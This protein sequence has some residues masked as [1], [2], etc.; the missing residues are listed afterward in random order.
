[1][2]S[3]TV[4]R[5]LVSSAVIL[6][7]C[8]STAPVFGQVRIVAEA[9]SGGRFGVGKLEI[10]L[11]KAM[12]PEALGLEA[13]CLT[14]RDGRV[15]YPTIHAPAIGAVVKEILS[16][17][18]PLLRG[19]P[20]ARQVG[21]LLGSILDRPPKATIYFLFRGD[22]PL[23][24]TLQG[25]TA[26]RMTVLARHDPVASRNLLRAW[27]SQYTA[28]PGLLEK[29]PD[30]PPLVD[31]YLKTTLARRLSLTLPESEQ[32]PSWQVELEEALGLMLGTESIRI[33]MQQDRIL[34]LNNLDQVAD[35]PL[36]APLPSPEATTPK[37]PDDVEVEPIAMR[38]PEE[39]FYVRFGSFANFL[40]MQ[41]T[42]AKW[43]GDLQNLLATRGLSYEMSQRM[44][45]QLVL[46]Q[47]ALS[48]MLG[49]TLIADVAII[50]NDM[51]FREGAAYGIL[52]YARNSALLGA[53]FAAQRLQRVNAG[54]VTE[55]K[56]KLGDSTVSLLASPDGSVRSYYA[57]DGDFHLVTTSRTLAARFLE[58]KSAAGSLGSSDNFRHARALMPLKRED[59][60]FVYF[61]DAF[62]RTLTGPHYR[63]EMARRL[64]AA[65]DVDLVQLAVL[66]SASEGKPGDTIAQLIAGELLPPEFGPR[67]DGSRTVLE[68]GQVYDQLRG[69]RGA[70]LPVPDVPT[71]QITRAELA[72]YRRFT[73]FYREKWGPLDPIMAAVKREALPEN[74]EKVTLD[75]RMSPLASKQYELLAGVVGSAEP[76]Q[77]APIPGDI[78][79]GEL[80]LKDQRLFGG[81]ADFGPPLQLVDGQ[82][83]PTGRLRDVL[84]GYVGVAG[85]LGL[86]SL[87]DVQIPA[88]P[89]GHGYSSNRLGLWRRQ[90]DQFTV[91]SLHPEVLAA[92]TPR[93]QFQQAVRPAQLRMRIG[94]VSHARMT[95]FLNNWGYA[96]TRETSLSNLR[97]INALDQQLHVP[98]EDCRAAAELLLDAKLVCPLGGQYVFQKRPDGSGY[99][100]STALAE[101]GGSLLSMRA[102]EGYQAPPL[103]W[104][105]G[106]TLDGAM[107]NEALTAHVEIIMQSPANE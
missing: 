67:P 103:N 44:E 72:A 3:N 8:A 54:G 9:F 35:Q 79:A 51:F 76:S 64:Q 34:G 30:Y 52:F 5:G 39:C 28:T 40:W 56:I 7:A 22:A 55:T 36:P 16:E 89:D 60:V 25:R 86:L 97:L 14:E 10:D 26:Y 13:L 48:R 21:G 74:R 69:H 99:W 104:F 102:P 17:D 18:S 23:E 107:T 4:R 33:A 37:P 93:L 61:S 82:M 84:V 80:V 65:A 12:L 58:T 27:W 2:R 106:L 71:D 42:L 50:G 66:A 98:P 63:V 85:P 45:T 87:L 83:L 73:D 43:Q 90:F 29:K 59:T 95:P 46:K 20:L 41:D 1:M 32:A 94:D 101:A 6:L 31:S 11:H 78:A 91:F 92:V 75:L 77:L 19:R 24:L 105:R 47:N 81:L 38:V 96:R 53:D 88:A 70:L 68:D 57:T 100:T 62:F 15:L 49:G